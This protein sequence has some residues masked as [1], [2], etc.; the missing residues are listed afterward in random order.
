MRIY[1]KGDY[2]Y[3]FGLNKKKKLSDYFIDNKFSLIEKENT[4]LLCMQDKIL[5]II[6]HTIDHRF[7]V[8]SSTRKVLRILIRKAS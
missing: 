2:F 4:P 6:G 3:P 1:R 8:K 5:A 7:Q